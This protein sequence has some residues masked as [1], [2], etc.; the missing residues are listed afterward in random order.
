MHIVTKAKSNCKA[1]EQPSKRV[2]RGRPS[3]KGATVKLFTLFESQKHSFTTTEIEM[4]GKKETVSYYAINLLWGQKLYQEL[5]FVLVQYQ[6]KTCILVSTDLKQEPETI[7]RLYSYRFKIE[8][9]FREMKQVIGG[10]GYQFWSK[11]MPKLKRYLKKTESHPLESVT[12]EKERKCILNTIYAIEGY[13]MYSCIALGLLQILSM[14]FSGR[15]NWTA[16]RYLRTPSK[17]IVSEAT[18]A[19]YLRKSIFHSLGKTK[20]LTITRIIKSKQG[21]L[22]FYEDLQAC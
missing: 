19:D 8:C 18:M 4:Y 22:E 21:D 20:D 15:I 14:Q 10:F 2:G 7:I 11:S 5:R 16:I 1:Y 17:E 9:T 6:D 12:A 3:K 13:V